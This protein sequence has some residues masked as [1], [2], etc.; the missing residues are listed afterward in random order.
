VQDPAIPGG[1]EGADTLQITTR[2]TYGQGGEMA[3]IVSIAEVKRPANETFA[4]VIDPSTMSE[5]QQGVVRGSLDTPETQVGSKCT[6]VRK[7]GGREREVV[8]KITEYDPP[9]TWADR[10]ISGP[11]RAMVNVK[12]E[13][14]S[15]GS[16]SRVTIELDFTGHGIGKLLVPLFVRPQAAKEMPENMKRLKQRLEASTQ[17]HG[18]G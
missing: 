15:D 5:W 7:I 11:I 6:T 17:S 1:L 8:T 2:R 10:G 18:S 12:V 3:P 9:H 4:Y 16:E 13:S 14:L